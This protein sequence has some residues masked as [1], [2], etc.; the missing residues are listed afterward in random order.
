MKE[1]IKKNKLRKTES[2]QIKTVFF[3]YF[4]ISYNTLK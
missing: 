3:F 1:G 4:L 2:E